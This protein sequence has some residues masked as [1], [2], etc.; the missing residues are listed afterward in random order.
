MSPWLNVTTTVVSLEQLNS[1][2]ADT[3]GSSEGVIVTL[4]GTD[5]IPVAITVTS[6][7]PFV[8]APLKIVS[9]NITVKLR[10]RVDGGLR[11]GLGDW[12]GDRIVGDGIAD[13]IRDG[14]ERGRKDGIGNG[15]RDRLGNG[16]GIGDGIGDGEVR[17]GLHLHKEAL[18]SLVG[19]NWTGNP[20]PSSSSS[21]QHYTYARMLDIHVAATYI[22][23]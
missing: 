23:N 9:L 16:D 13:G 8:S 6:I 2:L 21:A 11:D 12:I 3:R 17:W 20:I 5:E 10:G 1:S 15:I 19:G 7:M 4:Y 14:V 22:H 18:S